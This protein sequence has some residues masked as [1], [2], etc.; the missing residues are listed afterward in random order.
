MYHQTGL[1]VARFNRYLLSGQYS[2]LLMISVIIPTLNEQSCLSGTL[3]D[4]VRQ[5]GLK[6]IIIADGGSSDGTREIAKL[7]GSVVPSSKG[8]AL[9]M[10]TG[11]LHS[12]GDILL[13]LHA[14][15]ILPPN[16]LETIKKAVES[17]G[18]EA[19][20]FRLTFDNKSLLLNFYSY[21]TQFKFKSICFG[22]R[23]LFVRRDVFE[24]LGRF[25][26]VPLFEDLMIVKRLSKRGKFIYL[27]DSVTTA[28]RRFDSKGHLKQQCLNLYLWLRYM[29]GASP[30]KIHHLY[31]YESDC[32][33]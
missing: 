17:E 19:G 33:S 8:R 16:G 12:R 31:T 13:F 25:P 7:Y 3:D 29:L 11:A 30:E 23:G 24:S 22:D 28:S 9:Q 10:N 21:C 20:A 14:D 26:E 27:K 4:L 5:P 1:I 6:E 2:I 15:T 18:Y 32:N